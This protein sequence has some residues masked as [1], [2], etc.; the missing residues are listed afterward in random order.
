MSAELKKLTEDLNREWGEFKAVLSTGSE[1]QKKFGTRLGDTDAKL[2][3]INERLSAIETAAAR[4]NLEVKVGTDAENNSPEMKAAKAEFQA[5]LRKGT[6]LTPESTKLLRVEDDETGGFGAP[7]E[8]V[9]G[10]IKGV[11]DISPVRGTVRVRNTGNR[12]VRV[13]KRT[14]TFAAVW[15]SEVGTKT[16]TTGLK[17]GLEEIPTHEIYALVDI[18]N[19]DLE[20]TD[21]D[22]E[23]ELR[24]EFSEQF[25]V[26]ESDA[27]VNGDANGKPEGL[28]T[29]AAVAEVNS[30][31]AN[32][33]TYDGIVDLSHS[34]KMGYIGN[35]RYVFNLSTLGAMRKITNGSGEPLWAPMASGAPATITGW[36]YV[37]WQDMPN[38]GAGLYP[39]LFG[40]FN[41]A[42][43]L[44]D[45][46][47]MEILRDPFTQSTAGA[48]RFIARK[49]LG[50]QVVIAEAVRKQKVSA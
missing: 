15:V 50:G 42:Y 34:I 2:D 31:D 1:E 12:S 4:P 21:F 20:D 30:G 14:G 33:L 17:Y 16:E 19:Q 5:F 24:T 48:V 27:V 36:P 13:M 10:I 44:V 46:I 41:R 6:L 47:N 39:V 9:A 11:I 35:A 8:M 25:A 23:G 26:A 43:W 22:L 18:S 32:L 7:P 37:I 38:E 29:N 45:R 40:D 3:K 28:L 49:R